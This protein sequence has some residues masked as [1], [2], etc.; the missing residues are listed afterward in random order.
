MTPKRGGDK[1]APGLY[2]CRNTWQIVPISRKPAPLPGPQE[3]SYW[4][5]PTLGM[6]LVG[7]ILGALFVVF[8]PFIGFALLI[9]GLA[10]RGLQLASSKLRLIYSG[11]K[12][13][14]GIGKATNAE[15]PGER[16]DQANDD[17]KVA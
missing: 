7:P 10:S 8:L 9:H 6:L 11:R 12:M 15:K 3:H 4:R 2:W 17:H 14:R 5:V 13:A 16:A 1:V